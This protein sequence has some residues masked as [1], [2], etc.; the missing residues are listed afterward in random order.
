LAEI[1]LL[2]SAITVNASAGASSG[3]NQF[4]SKNRRNRLKSFAVIYLHGMKKP[5]SGQQ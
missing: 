3:E 4:K 5:Y 1:H 2:L